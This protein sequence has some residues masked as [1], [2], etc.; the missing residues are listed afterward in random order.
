MLT[1]DR[2]LRELL[3]GLPGDADRVN[4]AIVDIPYAVMRRH[5]LAGRVIPTS[6]D[7]IVADCARALIAA[8]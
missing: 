1:A 5:L 6:A 8:G 2:R 7:D 3:G 4:V